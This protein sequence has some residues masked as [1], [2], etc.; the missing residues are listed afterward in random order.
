MDVMN[1]RN[2]GRLFNRLSSERVCPACRQAL[3]EKFQQVKMYLRENPNSSVDDVSRENDVSVKQ[4]KQWVREERL[5]FSDGSV[6]GITCESCGKV[7]HTGRFCD[8]C[9]LEMA[10][11]MMAAFENPHK[12]EEI[13][14]KPSH[15]GDRMRFL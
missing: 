5:I 1:C 7:I 12:V 4:I 6:E 2:C 8:A 11:H 9:K 14:K 13:K 3:E 10:N 15:E